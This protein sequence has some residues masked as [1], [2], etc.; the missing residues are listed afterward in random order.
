MVAASV[1][2][3]RIESFGAAVGFGCTSKVICW[4]EMDAEAEAE[5]AAV[6]VAATGMVA[7]VL[8]VVVVVAAAVGRKAAARVVL[9]EMALS[10][11]V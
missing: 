9:R 1:A 7:K 4:E 5:V 11:A 3:A 8:L 2:K 6:G 10:P